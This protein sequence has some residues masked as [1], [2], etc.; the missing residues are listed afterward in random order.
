MK[1]LAATAKRVDMQIPS[2]LK[3]IPRI[4]EKSQ[5]RRGMKG[6]LLFFLFAIL[7]ICNSASVWPHR[8][9]LVWRIL[10]EPWQFWITWMTWTKWLSVW[11]TCTIKWSL[12]LCGRKTDTWKPQA[13]VVGATWWPFLILQFAA[14]WLSRAC[15]L[16]S[17]PLHA[18]FA[19]LLITPAYFSKPQMV[20]I[21][22]NGHICEIQIAHQQMLAARKGLAGHAVFNRVRNVM[23]LLDM[24]LWVSQ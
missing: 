1:A 3:K 7:I 10:S 18:E 19:P 8:M 23:E 16:S 9:C 17:V 4:V 13:V 21:V 11:L 6:V 12:K 24:T 2:E 14:S 22:V 15:G 5:L 20:N